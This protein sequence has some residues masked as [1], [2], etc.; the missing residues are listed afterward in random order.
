[1]IVFET[2]SVAAAATASRLYDIQLFSCTH[3][4]PNTT[5]TATECCQRR[6]LLLSLLRLGEDICHDSFYC[7]CRCCLGIPVQVLYRAQSK[8]TYSFCLYPHVAYFNFHESIPRH[9]E[10]Q[11]TRAELHL[12]RVSASP[13]KDGRS[14][15]QGLCQFER[16]GVAEKAPEE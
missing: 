4:T 11:K 13:V 5:Y 3:V 7:F 14:R 12:V 10:K 6:L 1:M 15:G 16:A 2:G 9:R 8:R